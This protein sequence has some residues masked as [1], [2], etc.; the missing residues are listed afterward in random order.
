MDFNQQYFVGIS[1]DHSA[2]MRTP[3]ESS[4]YAL[5]ANS[6]QWYWCFEDARLLVNSLHWMQAASSRSA[7]SR[8]LLL[9]PIT[10]INTIAGDLTGNFQI[11]AGTGIN[12]VPGA[13][14][15]TINSTA[16]SGGIQTITTGSGLIGG[17]SGST[18]FL[19]IAPGGI[20]QQ[21]LA[22]GSVGGIKLDPAL[23]GPGLFKDAAGNLEEVKTDNTT[24]DVN[25]GGAVE[26]AAAGVGTVQ[27]ANGSVTNAKIANGAVNASKVDPTQIQL[28]VTG[29]APNGSFIQSVNQDGTVNSG[30]VFVDPTL[31]RTVT[32]GSN[33]TLGIN[34]A[35]SNT[36]TGTQ[37]FNGGATASTLNVTGA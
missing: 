1:V 18:V 34:L 36:W 25:A 5:N 13:N 4:P 28:R 12:I 17:G 27:L 9:L 10:T 15:I 16:S 33:L 19:N 11:N 21:M 24:L 31:V 23:A 32:P 26:I 3:M 37:N 2:E 29:V 7:Y 20:T 8:H 6:V 14:S 30:T 35:N 22:D